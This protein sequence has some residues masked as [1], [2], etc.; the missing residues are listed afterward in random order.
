MTNE[1]KTNQ[2]AKAKLYKSKTN[3]M[4][5][6]VCGG[7]A[8]Y[9]N[10]DV[11]LVRIIWIISIFLDGLGAIAYLACLFLMS[12]NP[13]PVS[14]QE[15]RPV[16]NFAMIWGVLLIII[17]LIA[18][19][20]RWDFY[21]FPFHFRFW[22]PFF[23]WG[24]FWPLLIVLAGIL[25]IVHVLKKDKE[26]EKD[27]TKQE[28]RHGNRLTR[29]PSQ[30]MISGVCAGIAKF[31]SID[32]VIVRVGW[33]LLTIFTHGLGLIAYIV[34][35]FALPEERTATQSAPGTVSQQAVSQP[36]VNMNPV[37]NSVT[38]VTSKKKDQPKNEEN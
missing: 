37:Q 9:F 26:P 28:N 29:I 19:S 30:K 5:G 35:I 6:G 22:G 33:V 13:E 32:V 3:R 27:E 21:D 11:T 14:A 38:N 24:T 2:T 4:I 12:E 25:Y 34:L 17:G 10:I 23:H 36:N 7:V 15:P 20:N 1:P 16:K 18:L 31:L 8:E